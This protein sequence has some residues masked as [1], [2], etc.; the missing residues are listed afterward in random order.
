MMLPGIGLERGMETE[1]MITAA[2]DQALRTNAIKAKVEKQNL[3]P[4]CR[5]SQW[6]TWLESVA[7]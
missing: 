5:T 7:S 2:Q 6:D 1:G 3:S 4:L